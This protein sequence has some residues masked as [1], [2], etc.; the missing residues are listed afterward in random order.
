MNKYVQVHICM[1]LKIL[2]KLKCAFLNGFRRHSR[3]AKR[4]CYVRTQ[5]AA[6]TTQAIHGHRMQHL[7][8]A[9][10]ADVALK[11]PPGPDLGEQG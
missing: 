7:L 6:H 2:S 4:P 10:H 11:L 9:V 5:H 1:L 3:L 8:I